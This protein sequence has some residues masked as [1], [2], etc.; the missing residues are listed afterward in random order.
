MYLTKPRSTSSE[1]EYSFKPLGADDKI[2]DKD[3]IEDIPTGRRVQIRGSF[4]SF[5][6]GQRPG[7]ARLLPG[8]N[9]VVRKS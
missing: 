7:Q 6:R 5:L 4:Y 8:V 1:F 3:F 2:T 9:D